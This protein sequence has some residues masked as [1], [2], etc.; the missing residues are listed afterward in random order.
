[1]WVRCHKSFTEACEDWE[2]GMK[3]RRWLMGGKTQTLGKDSNKWSIFCVALI[4]AEL[5]VFLQE[6]M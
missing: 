4:L 6:E 5:Y 1:M 3:G 2:R